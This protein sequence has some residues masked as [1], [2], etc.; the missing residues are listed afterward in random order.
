MAHRLH[1]NESLGQS[2]VLGRVF[3][4]SQKKQLIRISIEAVALDSASIEVHRIRHRCAANLS[5]GH[6]FAVDPEAM[7]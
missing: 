5:T 7:K 4:E 1:A 6:G 3:A 2:G